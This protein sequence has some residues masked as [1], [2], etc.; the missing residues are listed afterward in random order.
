VDKLGEL[1]LTSHLAA[2]TIG[3][4]ALPREGVSGPF[5]IAR[6]LGSCALMLKVPNSFAATG[7]RLRR[8]D[9]DVENLARR[10]GQR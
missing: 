8:A 3:L 10:A 7:A 2:V 5:G 6:L 9:Q 4:E 1:G